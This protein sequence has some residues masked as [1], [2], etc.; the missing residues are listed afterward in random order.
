M[1]VMLGLL[2]TGLA[3][4][5]LVLPSGGVGGF[6][7]AS[8][9][10]PAPTFRAINNA[11]AMMSAQGKTIREKYAEDASAMGTLGAYMSVRDDM[12][13]AFN[14]AAGDGPYVTL[15]SFGAVMTACG[16]ELLDDELEALFNEADSD[17]DGKIVFEHFTKAF[18]DSA[19]REAGGAGDEKKG[20]FG[21]F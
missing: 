16:E 2:A 14:G 15:E 6:V 4:S 9:T 17:G 11:I 7:V 18:C 21:L 3:I 1:E 8:A 5:G 19:R 20:F 12:V 10:N 13:R